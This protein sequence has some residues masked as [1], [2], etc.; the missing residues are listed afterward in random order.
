[1]TV[2]NKEY[3]AHYDGLYQT[4]DYVKECDLI[5]EIIQL[6]SNIESQLILDIGCG[7]GGHAIELIK[8]K[9]EVTGVDLSPHMLKVAEI[10]TKALE[11]Q[12]NNRWICG[13]IRNF[14]TGIK[15]DVCIMMFSVI[16]YLLTNEDI[17][18]AFRNIRKHMKPG[19][20][21]IFDFWSGPAVITSP[22][23]DR[24][25]EIKRKDTTIIRMGKTSLNIEKQIADVTF[26]V[27]ECNDI[28]PLKISEELHTIRYFFPKEIELFLSTS[29]F[30]LKKI[31]SFPEINN[32]I[33][34]NCWNGSAISIAV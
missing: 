16:G 29:G 25:K 18:I 21:L 33:D 6:H 3:A 24:I 8:R 27:W 4:K 9:Y 10:K 2:F 32:Q 1:M 17:L 7:T 23:T 19:G 28:T 31:S 12:A 34:V 26:K 15:Y 20:V 11:L 13:D 5:E 30:K 14:D 22:S